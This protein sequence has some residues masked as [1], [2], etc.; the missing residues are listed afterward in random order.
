MVGIM[1]SKD[2]DSMHEA[3]A[4]GSSDDEVPLQT[5]E[6][7]KRSLR[8]SMLQKLLKPIAPGVMIPPPDP[9]EPGGSQR[10]EVP[11]SVAK[12]R[13]VRVEEEEIKD[14]WMFHIQPATSS[15]PKRR[16][17]Y[18]NG[19]GFRMKP[20]KEHWKLCKHLCLKLACI[21]T[22]VSYPLAPNS[23]APQS[24]P[25]ILEAY[26]A[27]L[28]QAKE[29]GESI[30]VAGDSSGGNLAIS[31]SLAALQEQA[32]AGAALT[33]PNNIMLLSPAASLVNDIEKM[34]EVAKVDPILSYDYT[35]DVA[36]TWCGEWPRDDPRMSPVF[37]NIALAAAAHTK[38]HCIYASMD[39]LAPD[40]EVLQE[41]CRKAG[42]SGEWVK[43]TNQ[44]HVFPL[45][46]YHH[47]PRRES[48]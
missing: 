30:D 32:D 17:L 28:S 5:S 25:A 40:T 34:E 9:P 6:E 29:R 2:N 36:K 8:M 22:L 43:W 3:N 46:E 21:V 14:I 48:G 19:G 4:N 18:F 23:P 24:F 12:D 31:L 39:T 47:P 45:S 41:L 38:I 10:L 13:S 7:G 15:I 20:S 42:V 44:M 27:I 26:K 37:A 1:Q 35:D 33:G 16:M 11:K